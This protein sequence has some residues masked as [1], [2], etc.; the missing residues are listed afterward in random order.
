MKI[1]RITVTRYEYELPDLSLKIKGF[2]TLYSPGSRQK[3]TG[4]ILTIETN[5]GIVGETQGTMNERTA[6]YLLGRDPFQREII[7]HDL[8]RSLRHAGGTPPGDVDVALWDIAGKTYNVPVYQLLGGWR[9]KLPA[10]PSTYHGDEN[11]GYSSPEEYA[12]FARLCKEKYGYKGFK[13]HGWVNGPIKREV[14]AVLAIRDAVGDDFD[15]MLDPAGG[16]GTFHDVL[17]VGKACDEA[18]YMWYEDPFRGGGFSQFAHAK[19]RQMIKTPILMGEHVRGLEGKMDMIH[20]GAT[21]YVRA[22]AAGDGGI[23]GIMKL[24]SIAEA[25]GLD[26]ELHGGSLAHRHCMASIRNTNYFELGVG[27]HK[28]HETKAPIFSDRQW[29]DEID[30]VDKDGCIDVPEGP[31]LGVPLD[32]DFIN[33]HKTGT[34]VFDE[35]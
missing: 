21:D 2:D 9:K 12:D 29:M 30:S 14:A 5:S 16:F 27:I 23:T 34:T 17:R 8:K 25:S 10:Y 28:V 7:W 22:S 19:L 3:T 6:N 26:V 1:N 32:W 13:I 18:N 31:G 11:G 35:T 15:L 4:S 24:A 33:S 20:S